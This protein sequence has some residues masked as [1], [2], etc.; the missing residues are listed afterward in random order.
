MGC[1]CLAWAFQ[2]W[3][4]SSYKCL[5]ALSVPQQYPRGAMSGQHD[6]VTLRELCFSHAAYH[7]GSDIEILPVHSPLCPPAQLPEL[8]AVPSI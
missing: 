6:K 3:Q 7:A 8:R 2:A 5:H 1:K 4:L